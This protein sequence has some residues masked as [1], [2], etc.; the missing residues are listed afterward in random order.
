[1]KNLTSAVLVI[2]LYG[3][4]GLRQL[5]FGVEHR[6]SMR[7]IRQIEKIKRRVY[8]PY[9]VEYWIGSKLVQSFIAPN[10]LI[11]YWTRNTLV[12]NNGYNVKGFKIIKV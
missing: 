8:S 11:A 1:M 10:R 12:Q 7:E 9:K 6:P 4:L 5:H 2:R 3:D